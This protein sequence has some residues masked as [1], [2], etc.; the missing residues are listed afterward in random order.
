MTV[1]LATEVKRL[2]TEG[3]PDWIEE[4]PELRRR[5]RETIG[6]IPRQPPQKR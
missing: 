3:L 4:Q 1:P 5:L 2:V 6:E